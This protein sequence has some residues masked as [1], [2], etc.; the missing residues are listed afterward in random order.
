MRSR[1]SICVNF[2][3]AVEANDCLWQ[4][5]SIAFCKKMCLLTTLSAGADVV[6][7]ITSVSPPGTIIG[8]QSRIVISTSPCCGHVGMSALELTPSLC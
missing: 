4:Y 2:V 1:E 3:N 7:R 6:P 8:S 5:V